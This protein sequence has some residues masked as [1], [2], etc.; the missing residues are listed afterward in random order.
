MPSANGRA[1]V[2]LDLINLLRVLNADGRAGVGDPRLS[3][4]EGGEVAGDLKIATER[5]GEKQDV[6]VMARGVHPGVVAEG[7]GGQGVAPAHRLGI[8]E[9]GANPTL[10]D[11]HIIEPGSLDTLGHQ[12]SDPSGVTNPPLHRARRIIALDDLDQII[13]Q[14]DGRRSGVRSLGQG[15]AGDEFGPA[16]PVGRVFADRCFRQGS[17]LFKGG[18]CLLRLALSVANE[19]GQSESRSLVGRRH[20]LGAADRRKEFIELVEV[21]CHDQQI[22]G[23]AFDCG[24]DRDSRPNC[25][26]RRRRGRGVGRAEPLGG[27][28]AEARVAIGGQDPC[29]QVLISVNRRQLARG[30]D[31]LSG[32]VEKPGLVDH[33]GGGPAAVPI[34]RAWLRREHLSRLLRGQSGRPV[35]TEDNFTSAGVGPAFVVV[36]AEKP[37]VGGVERALVGELPIH[38][39]EDVI[40]FDPQRRRVPVTRFEGKRLATAGLVVHDVG[41]ANLA[42]GLDSADQGMEA[43]PFRLDQ[44]GEVAKARMDGGLARLIEKFIS[45]R[46]TV[47]ERANIRQAALRDG[48]G[49]RGCLDNPLV[50]GVCVRID[51]IGGRGVNASASDL[52]VDGVPVVTVGLFRFRDGLAVTVDR[53]GRPPRRDGLGISG[54]VPAVETIA[55]GQIDLAGDLRLAG[56]NRIL[57]RGQAVLLGFQDQPGAG[58][59]RLGVFVE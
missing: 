3:P 45:D 9:R 15:G 38:F 40:G 24:R 23:R 43:N 30:S 27:G 54:S 46:L 41:W 31:D 19:C 11:R 29:E 26:H 5:G 22:Q 51:I 57:E 16:L 55:R 17:K 12:P 37:V 48:V 50:V 1:A 42:R 52:A 4:V 6:V 20:S 7:P 36:E 21:F 44:K 59:G 32:R 10:T 34:V 2:V 14:A 25:R 13:E 58:G 49:A 18:L 28:E 35:A 8:A 56:E 53:L 33:R 47:F 39:H